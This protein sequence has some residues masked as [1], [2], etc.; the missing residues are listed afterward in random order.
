MRSSIRAS[1]APMQWWIPRP[2][3]TINGSHRV[4]AGRIAE[5]NSDIDAPAAAAV[6]LA[7]LTYFRMIDVVMGPGHNGVDQDRFVATWASIYRSLL[8]PPPPYPDR[9]GETS[10]EN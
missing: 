8:D 4:V 6:M 2:N 9:T 1:A 5:K 7:A 3:D 10:S